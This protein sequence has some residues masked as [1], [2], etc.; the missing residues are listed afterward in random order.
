MKRSILGLT[1]ATIFAAPFLAAAQPAMAQGREMLSPGATRIEID[2]ERDE[3]HFYIKG[4]VAAIL[5]ADGLHVRE[6]INL[7]G[8]VTDYGVAGFDKR[9]DT[10][11]ATA[12]TIEP[13]P[14]SAEGGRDAD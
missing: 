10:S 1:I 2:P 8:S 9:R 12:D 7:G 5:R 3:I 14:P 6:H 4:E 11:P 13:D